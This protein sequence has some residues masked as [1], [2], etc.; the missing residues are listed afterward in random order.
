MLKQL[1]LVGLLL[2]T[3]AFADTTRDPQLQKI[4]Q[5]G[6]NSV[7]KGEYQSATEYFR[8]MLKKNPN[9]L[10]PR[11]EL[12]RVLYKMENYNVAK[13]HFEQVLSVNLPSNV[14]SNVK[15]FLTLI[16]Q[17]LPSFDFSLN[18]SLNQKIPKRTKKS[19][20]SRWQCVSW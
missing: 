7:S 4:F 18:L 10:R 1:L 13:Y 19:H 8:L 15:N 12:A 16:R 20:L 9:L 2:S 11:L 14:R 17:Q 6:M 3:Y 5:Q